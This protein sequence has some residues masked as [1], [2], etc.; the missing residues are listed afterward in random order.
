[1]FPALFALSYTFYLG[2]LGLDPLPFTSSKLL[3]SFSNVLQLSLAF[4]TSVQGETPSE[5]ISQVS[6][7][8][9]SYVKGLGRKI[10]VLGSPYLTESN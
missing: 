2:Q 7:C 3:S 8:N 6:V 9:S 1:M 10:V 5:Q 4:R